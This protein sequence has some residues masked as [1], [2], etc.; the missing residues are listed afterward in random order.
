[1]YLQSMYR[2]GLKLV[3]IFVS[4]MILL[5]PSPR[6]HFGITNAIVA[7]ATVSV[8]VDRT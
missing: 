4:D 7:R 6:K 8:S 1:M 3:V 5:S 2:Y